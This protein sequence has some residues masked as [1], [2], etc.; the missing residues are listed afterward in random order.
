MALL[1]LLALFRT[2]CVNYAN[3]ASAFFHLFD[4]IWGYNLRYAAKN[5]K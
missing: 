3:C 2:N 5:L 4:A 1:T